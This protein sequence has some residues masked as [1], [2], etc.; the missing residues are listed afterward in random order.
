MK[1]RKNRATFVEGIAMLQ[2][3]VLRWENYKEKSSEKA[4]II[5]VISDT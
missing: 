2:G 1:N 4:V 3:C 5:K